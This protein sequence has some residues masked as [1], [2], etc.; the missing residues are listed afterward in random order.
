MVVIIIIFLIIIII[1]MLFVVD[2]SCLFS[3]CVVLWWHVTWN[4]FL[5]VRVVCWISRT[6]NYVCMYVCIYSFCLL[7]SQKHIQRIWSKVTQPYV[8][9]YVRTYRQKYIVHTDNHTF[10]PYYF[11]KCAVLCCYVVSHLYIRVS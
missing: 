6:Y 7:L 8:H 1:V 2:R 9:M 11:A 3:I 10:Q 4:V 5:I